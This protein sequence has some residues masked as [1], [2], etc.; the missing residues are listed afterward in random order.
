MPKVN[1]VSAVQAAIDEMRAQ[2][3]DGRWGLGDRLPSEAELSQVMG[4]SRA[5]LREATRAL[6]HAGLL[7]VRQGDGTYVVALD[8]ATVALSR[9]LMESKTRDVLEVRRGL[10]ASAVQLAVAR[11]TDEDLEAMDA[12]LKRRR[13]A[14]AQGDRQAFIDADV[15]FHVAVAEAAHNALLLHLYEGLSIAIRESLDTARSLEHAISEGG[16][17]HVAL[18]DAIKSGDEA[19]AVETAI[20]IIVSQEKQCAFE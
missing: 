5:P 12:A 20:S 16:D 7:S 10:D 1:R 2:I 13:D 17:D 14:T 4:I 19:R 15:A 18:F 8:E 9:K 6:V 3:R 11:R